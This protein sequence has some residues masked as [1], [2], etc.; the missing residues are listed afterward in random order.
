MDWY[1]TL[2]SVEDWRGTVTKPMVATIVKAI[3][4]RWD[5]ESNSDECHRARDY[6]WRAVLRAVAE[7]RCDDPEGCSATVLLLED[8]PFSRWYS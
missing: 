6:L 7:K 3:R 2:D 1:E 4:Q 8:V 5:D